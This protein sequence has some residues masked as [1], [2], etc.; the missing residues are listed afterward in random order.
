MTDQELQQQL[1]Q[2][3]GDTTNIWSAE[4]ISFLEK[5]LPECISRINRKVE[6]NDILSAQYR[7][8]IVTSYASLIEK[9]VRS[10]AAEMEQQPMILPTQFSDMA[11]HVKDAVICLSALSEKCAPELY[12]LDSKSA[13]NI[14]FFELGRLFILCHQGYCIGTLLTLIK[15]QSWVVMDKMP[16]GYITCELTAKDASETFAKW[17]ENV[18]E[19]DRESAEWIVVKCS[20]LGRPPENKTLQQI[21]TLLPLAFWL[22]DKTKNEMSEYITRELNSR[23]QQYQDVERKNGGGE[24]IKF[25]LKVCFAG[26]VYSGLYSFVHSDMLVYIVTNYVHY[27][28]NSIEDDV[29]A[30]QYAYYAAV[31]YYFYRFYRKYKIL[32]S[33]G[34]EEGQ[35]SS[36]KLFIAAL[37]WF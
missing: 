22:P 10:I 6:T 7:L 34:N 28:V 3:A 18:N 30:C 33:T 15:A 25:L 35:T 14:N 12:Q 2:Y 8:N 32:K 20:K 11:Q 17:A 27:H 13:S 37:P 21:Q 1:S 24:F 19:L 26:I 36:F 23:R 29:S 4:Y 5:I 9:I 31:F 16:T